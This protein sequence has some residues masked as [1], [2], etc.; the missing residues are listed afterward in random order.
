MSNKLTFFVNLVLTGL[1][2]F[3]VLAFHCP[4]GMFLLPFLFFVGRSMQLIGRYPPWHEDSKEGK[5]V[6]N[7]VSKMVKHHIIIT[8]VA[9]IVF[10][11]YLGPSAVVV[12]F[13]LFLILTGLRLLYI[14]VTQAVKE[15]TS[16]VK[17][18]INDHAISFTFTDN[19]LIWA[20]YQGVINCVTSGIHF[21]SS[22]KITKATSEPT[23]NEYLTKLTKLNT[24]F[25]AGGLSEAEYNDKKAALLPK[26]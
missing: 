23:D 21:V 19:G 12:V 18:A 22:F 4:G 25:Q 9:G 24:L 17:E 11:S 7:S 8:V 16:L 6:W 2:S 5:Q 1:M 20:V 3:I 13:V 14:R 26:I 15:P 10:G